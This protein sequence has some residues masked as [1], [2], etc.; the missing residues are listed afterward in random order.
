MENAA[1]TQLSKELSWTDTEEQHHAAAQVCG[2]AACLH[3]GEVSW[4]QK[5]Q[6][7]PLGGSPTGLRGLTAAE[8]GAP[9]G[10]VQTGDT[11]GRSCCCC[12]SLRAAGDSTVNCP[13]AELV[14]TA[15]GS[16]PGDS[17]PEALGEPA[18]R[19]PCRAPGVRV[20]AAAS[21]GRPAQRWSLAAFLCAPR[22]GVPGG[23]SP[24]PD[25]GALAGDSMTLSLISLL[26]QDISGLWLLLKTSTGASSL[27]FGA[28]CEWRVCRERGAG[29]PSGDG[30]ARHP[31]R[32]ATERNQALPG[33]IREIQAGVERE[34]LL[35][36]LGT[37]G[38]VSWLLWPPGLPPCPGFSAL[39]V[40]VHIATLTLGAGMDSGGLLC[41][42]YRYAC[43]APGREPRACECEDWSLAVTAGQSCPGLP[44]TV[45]SDHGLSRWQESGLD[46]AGLWTGRPILGGLCGLHLPSLLPTPWE[47]RHF[48]PDSGP[49]QTQN[50][51]RGEGIG[52][53]P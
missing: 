14:A 6:T 17:Q 34:V 1:C 19:Q 23:R 31:H 27:R 49:Q 22:T 40:K 38:I 13:Q 10:R 51:D 37:S 41:S 3:P 24:P 29:G 45:H 44:C 36:G 20:P 16:C 18:G 15:G 5:G 33:L 32:P 43:G 35:Q 8:R 48:S 39:G 4:G 9:A 46:W 7:R 28:G 42:S 47:G 30:L 52:W 50:K 26:S 12:G 53:V 2:S 11:K 21:G 25:A